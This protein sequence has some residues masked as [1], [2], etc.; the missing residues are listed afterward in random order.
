MTANISDQYVGVLTGALGKLLHRDPR[1]DVGAAMLNV[2]NDPIGNV[3]CGGRNRER[4]A[5]SR[6]RAIWLNSPMVIRVIRTGSLFATMPSLQKNKPAA[7][8]SA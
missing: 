7:S 6:A 1:S 4:F 5:S 8:R 2:K 3:S